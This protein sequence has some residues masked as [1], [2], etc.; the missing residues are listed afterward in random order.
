MPGLHYNMHDKTWGGLHTFEAGINSNALKVGGVSIYGGPMIRPVVYVVDRNIGAS[1]DGKS[2]DTA[3]K[4]ITEAVEQVNSDYT[5]TV[6]PCGGRNRTIVIGEGWYSE[7]TMTLTA[8]D[9][10]IMGVGSGNMGR[11]VLYGSLTAGGWDDGN[12]G[13]SL[14]ITGWNNTIANMDFVNRAA[15][16]SGVYAGGHAILEHPC[17]LEGT[18]ATAAG[19]N[20]YVGLGFMRD[21]LDCASYGILS[22][23]QD[24]TLVEDC[25]FN[26]ASL[27]DGGIAMFK[28]TSTNHSADIVR[29]NYFFGCPVG[30]FQSGGHNLML[31]DN[32][33]TNQGAVTITMT[34]A[35][36]V[37]GHSGHAFNN[38]ALDINLTSFDA[39]SVMVLLK[40]LCANST[41][42]DWPEMS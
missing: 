40:N 35:I 30:L 22:Y 7:T 9:C 32:V 4:T 28:G 24:H 16:V 14:A 1:G 17:I 10:I 19:Y 38:Y 34:N 42:T 21:Q 37:E 26:G 8:S 5:G 23:S 29:N 31:H 3:F 27:R 36:N 11:T 6:A 20:R 33:F 39:G 2:W 13:P 25:I 18:Y 41:N 15:T 12:L